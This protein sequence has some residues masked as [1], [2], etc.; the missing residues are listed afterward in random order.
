[1][2]FL[3]NNLTCRALPFEWQGKEK[4]DILLNDKE[5][6]EMDSFGFQEMQNIQK[7]LQEKYKERWGGLSPEKGGAACSG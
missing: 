5:G 2:P 3:N 7:E 4:N 1:M 6:I